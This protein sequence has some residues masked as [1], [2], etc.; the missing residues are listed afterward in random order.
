MPVSALVLRCASVAR[1]WSPRHAV[2]AE[3][4]VLA[5]D[6]DGFQTFAEARVPLGRTAAIRAVVSRSC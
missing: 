3:V 1:P 5:L 4:E 2:D 6:E